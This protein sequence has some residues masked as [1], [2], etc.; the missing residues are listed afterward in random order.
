MDEVR[1]YDFKK[2]EKFSLENIR[3]LT[4]IC[5]EFCKTSKM[6]VNYETK[7]SNLKMSV[8]KSMQSTYGEFI[9][10]IEDDNIVIEYSILP[11]VYNLT[12]FIDKSTILIFVDL[13]LGGNGNIEDKERDPTNID[14]ELLNY[15]FNNLLNRMYIPIPHE[16]VEINKIYTNKIQYQNLTSKDI[17]FTSLIDISLQNIVVGHIRFCIP[18]ESTKKIINDFNVK[19]TNNEDIKDEEIEKNIEGYEIYQYIKNINLDITA[20]L[21]TANVSIN[22]LLNLEIGDVII[23]EQKIN[24][25]ITVIIADTK[26]YK[27]KPGILGNKN[28]LEITDIIS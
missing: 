12:L 26:I 1:L 21:G 7:N 20:Q 9:E 22:D 8:N 18:Y 2:N 24:E 25:D 14:L 11:T 19:K 4:V 16:K 28:G 13:L 27:A 3:S 5:E 23:L 10:D 6:Q 17:I 15:L